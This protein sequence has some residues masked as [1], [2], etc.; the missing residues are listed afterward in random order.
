MAD[1]DDFPKM[2]L[3]VYTR[4]AEGDVKNDSGVRT[5][6]HN[7]KEPVDYSS[8]FPPCRC[9]RHAQSRAKVRR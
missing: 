3:R 7:A 9:P 2:T 6:A 8:A 5:I 4:T 1:E